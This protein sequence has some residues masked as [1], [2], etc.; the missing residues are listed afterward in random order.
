M[1]LPLGRKE[2]IY[3]NVDLEA[4]DHIFSTYPGIWGMEIK[5]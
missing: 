5:H 1:P 4:K 3:P 2:T